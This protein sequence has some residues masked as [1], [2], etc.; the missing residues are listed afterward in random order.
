MPSATSIS[1]DV[2]ESLLSKDFESLTNI[3]EVREYLRLIDEEETRIDTCLDTMLSQEQDL[4]SSLSILASLGP[5]LNQ[6]K[7]NSTR[8]I[9]TVDKTSRLAEVISDKV[10]QLDQEQSRAREAIKYVEDVQELKYCVASLQ[11]AM[12]KKQ[13]DEAAVLLQRASKIDTAILNGSLAEFTVVFFI[14][15][16]VFFCLWKAFFNVLYMYVVHL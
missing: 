6:L 5:R 1:P 9:D 12:S 13:Y 3:D 2:K 7:S 10:R 14:F 4:D 16:R 11:D 15:L 8:V